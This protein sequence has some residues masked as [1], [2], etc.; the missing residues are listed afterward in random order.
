MYCNDCGAKNPDGV[1]FCAGCGRQLIQAVNSDPLEIQMNF[2]EQPAQKKKE[3]KKKPKKGCLTAIIV[4][5]FLF[6]GVFSLFIFGDGNETTEKE[7]TSVNEISTKEE[8]P[9]IVN[10]SFFS[11]KFGKVMSAPGID[12]CF[13]VVL[14]IENKSDIDEAFLLEDVY[15]DDTAANFSGS[16][17]MQSALV[18]KKLNGTFC[19]F[20]PEKIENAEKLEFKIVCMD[21]NSLNRLE[22]TDTITINLK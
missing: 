9:I 16:G 19:I 21:K 7:T 15:I 8:K 1:K 3:Q 12:G 4:C 13:Y 10:D 5:A 17:L 20:Y 6:A 2:D 11:A 14:E 18:G 22:V